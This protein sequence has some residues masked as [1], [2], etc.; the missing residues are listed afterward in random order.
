MPLPND[1]N[2]KDKPQSSSSCIRHPNLLL[3]LQLSGRRR[4]IRYLLADRNFEYEG[5]FRMLNIYHLIS[6]CLSLITLPPRDSPVAH[7]TGE[8]TY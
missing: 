7:S 6:R 2:R 3:L 8:E 5:P 1:I 4:D